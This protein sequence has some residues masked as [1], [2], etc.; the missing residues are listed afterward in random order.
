M[1]NIL[2]VLFFCSEIWK[3]LQDDFYHLQT[4]INLVLT[5]LLLTV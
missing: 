4:G 3:V 2:V 5:L 1:V